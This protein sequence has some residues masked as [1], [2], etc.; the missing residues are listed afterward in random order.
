MVPDVL[1][2]LVPSPSRVCDS[3]KCQNRLNGRD[4]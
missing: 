2:E 1:K 4:V 3:I